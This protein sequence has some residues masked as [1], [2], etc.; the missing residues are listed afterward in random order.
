MSKETETEG[1]STIDGRE[2][3]YGSARVTGMGMYINDD[4]WEA[5]KAYPPRVQDSVVGSLMRLYFTG[6]DQ[7]DALT[8]K[9]A[10]ALYLAIR[11]RVAKA[12]AKARRRSEEKE[13]EGEGV[14]E[15]APESADKTR[16]RVPGQNGG[17][18]K[19]RESEREKVTTCEPLGAE[20]LPTMGLS[21]VGEPWA[22]FVGKSLER[23]EAVT[24]RACRI[25]SAQVVLCLRRVFEA[26]YTVDDVEAVCRH[27]QA[28]WAGDRRMD[29]FIRP[30]T[31]F[32]DKFEAYLAAAKADPGKGARDAADEFADAF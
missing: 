22:E 26:G 23:F 29:G 31:L 5:L 28:E 14:D 9:N 6:E 17:F 18:A 1:G 12:A 11:E 16:P 32:G 21:D 15:N 20:P 4:Y 25:P 2:L 10:R 7:L 24:G 19:K 8:N 30:Q 27:K 13:Q 3:D